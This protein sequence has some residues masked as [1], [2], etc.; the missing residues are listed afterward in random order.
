MNTMVTNFHKDLF[1]M[2]TKSNADN[3]VMGLYGN[4]VAMSAT[5]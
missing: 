5:S 1:I 3:N 2:T 4:Y